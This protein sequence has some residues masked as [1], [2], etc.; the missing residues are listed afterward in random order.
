MYMPKTW[1][2]ESICAGM[3]ARIAKIVKLTSCCTMAQRQSYSSFLLLVALH[4]LVLYVSNIWAPEQFFNEIWLIRAI[5]PLRWMSTRLRSMRV[6]I[7]VNCE[8]LFLNI[9]I[10]SN[11]SICRYVLGHEGIVSLASSRASADSSASD[12]TDGRFQRAHHWCPRSRCR[13]RW[14][15]INQMLWTYLKEVYL[16]KNVV[17]AGVKSVTIY[18]PE[19][20]TVQDLSTQVSILWPVCDPIL[21]W[22]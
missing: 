17:L 10:D 9:R 6:S 19:L 11:V 20:V 15:L 18:D 3:L 12:E 1:R 8:F 2:S 4:P 13:N 16:A 7:H 21:L 14:S 22:T 5:W